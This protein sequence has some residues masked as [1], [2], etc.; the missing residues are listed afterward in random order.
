MRRWQWIAVGVLALLAALALL[1]PRA[2]GAWYQAQARD[3]AFFADEIAAFAEQDRA[4]PPPRSPIV[5][6]GSSSIRMWRTLAEDMAPL[7]VLNRGFGGSQLAHVVHYAEETILRYAPRAVV[8][9]GGDNDLDASSGKT[10]EDVAR[11]F[12]RLAEIVRARLPEARLYFL[13]I[14][15]SRL[16]WARWPEMQRANA[17][18]AALCADDPRLAFVDVAAPLLGPDGT[19]RGDVFLFDGLHLND[20]GYAEWTRVVRAR[21]CRDLGG[22]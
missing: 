12:A 2:F 4:A 17:R 20:T 9:Y 19:P 3:P 15:P 8:V 13:S 11:D 21:L 6:V 1:G 16:R 18:I 10:A 14:K 22:C 7:P 5:F